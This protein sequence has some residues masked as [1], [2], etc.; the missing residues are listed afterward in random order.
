MAE[1]WNFYAEIS[2]ICKTQTRCGAAARTVQQQWREK[3]GRDN[4][5]TATANKWMTMSSRG[6]SFIS[7]CSTRLQQKVRFHVFVSQLSQFLFYFCSDVIHCFSARIYVCVWKL[8]GKGWAIESCQLPECN[9]CS[10]TNVLLAKYSFL[11][12]TIEHLTVYVSLHLLLTLSL[13]LSHSS[14]NVRELKKALLFDM[15]SVWLNA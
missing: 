2:G 12:E 11:M 15:Q 14:P 9:V 5:W 1:Y 7:I 3:Y 10:N 8:W 6:Q 4:K 13:S